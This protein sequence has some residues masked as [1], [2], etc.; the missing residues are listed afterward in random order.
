MPASLT[1]LSD[2]FGNSRDKGVAA[3][4]TAAAAAAAA[5]AAGGRLA[6]MSEMSQ[7]RGSDAAPSV[8]PSVASSSR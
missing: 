5:A 1:R 7:I 3:A 6:G 4:A 2:V 8:A